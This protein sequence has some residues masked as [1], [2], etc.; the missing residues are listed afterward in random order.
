MDAADQR[1]LRQREQVVVA[2]Q[3]AAPAAEALAAEL[4]LGEALALDH[5]AHGAVEDQDPLGEQRLQQ[6]SAIVH[7]ASENKNARSAFA[8]TGAVSV[9]LRLFSRIC[10]SPRSGG[11]APAS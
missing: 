2:A 4:L 6:G 9:Q 7:P 5:R 3:V 1:R 11:S 10:F 8:E